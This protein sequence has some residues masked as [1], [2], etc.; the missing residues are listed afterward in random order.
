M[1]D[2]LS[3]PTIKFILLPQPKPYLPPGSFL[4]LCQENILFSLCFA[5]RGISTRL[6]FGFG[7]HGTS[8][9]EQCVN[10]TYKETQSVILPAPENVHQ[11]FCCY[12]SLSTGSSR[13]QSPPTPET[14]VASNWNSFK[15]PG[16]RWWQKWQKLKLLLYVDFAS[17]RELG[18]WMG[19]NSERGLQPS[20]ILLFVEL[21]NANLNYIIRF[22]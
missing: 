8:R 2:V 16:I 1:V 4:K 21:L 17:S 14:K 20:F 12:H 7:T 9:T 22:T 15:T 6:T 3:S 5:H 13:R 11:L 19:R 10:T 18:W